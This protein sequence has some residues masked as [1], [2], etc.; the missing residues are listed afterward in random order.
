MSSP[1]SLERKTAKVSEACE[2]ATALWKS[3]KKISL[4][5]SLVLVII[6]M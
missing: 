6:Q 3:S 4:K 1:N 2:E 5:E